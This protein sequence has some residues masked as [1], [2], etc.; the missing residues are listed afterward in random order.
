MR[1]SWQKVAVRLACVLGVSCLALTGMP[2]MVWAAAAPGTYI[3]NRS[4]VVLPVGSAFLS[5]STGVVELSVSHLVNHALNGRSGDLRL[6]VYLTKTRYTGEGSIRGSV[7]AQKD[8]TS[9][10]GGGVTMFK[11]DKLRLNVN[12]YPASG[13]YYLSVVLTEF[14]GDDYYVTD[15]YTT[16]VTVL[17]PAHPV[18]K[19]NEFAKAAAGVLQATAEALAEQNANNNNTAGTSGAGLGQ[20]EAGGSTDVATLQLHLQR[21]YDQLNRDQN[22]LTNAQQRHSATVSRG[23]S[24]FSGLQNIRLLR[25]AVQRDQQLI[26]NLQHRIATS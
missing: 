23:R 9:L 5:T 12:H 15:F 18:I 17:V 8:F 19:Q 20:A 24:D 25:Q 7:I 26:A 2:D 4:A 10:P 22:A 14:C 13:R 16:P 3:L 11:N 6:L 1:K 21:A